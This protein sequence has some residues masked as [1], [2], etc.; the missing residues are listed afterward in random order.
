MPATIS[1]VA[2]EAGVSVSAVSAAINGREK[3]ARIS[4]AT[5]KRIWQ[6]VRKLGYRPRAAAR[7]LRSGRQEA[8][9]Y[10]CA[11]S[12]WKLFDSTSAEYMWGIA[13]ELRRAHIRM[14]VLVIEDLLMEEETSTQRFLASCHFDGIVVERPDEREKDIETAVGLLGLPVVWLNRPREDG[15]NCVWRDDQEAA[16]L[17]VEHLVSL[18]HK[19]I[20]YACLGNV[21]E[22]P[23]TLEQAQR[24]RGYERAMEQA[25]LAAR[26]LGPPGDW[27]SVDWDFFSERPAAI[28]A[29][30]MTVA[31]QAQRALEEKG[32]KV[33]ADLSL[34][35]VNDGIDAVRELVRISAISRDREG[36]GACAARKILTILGG[37]K[38]VTYTVFHGDLV[39]RGSTQ[40][41]SPDP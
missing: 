38:D 37:D 18:G 13:R 23:P 25:G 5:S 3:K 27:E 34:V 12:G 35:S 22:R 11:Q 16:E 24:R 32:L 6:V 36:M 4:A 21:D 28:V 15:L 7:A 39:D 9:G 10:L 14:I 40:R 26:F 1:D 8:V 2:R 33:P 31:W 29:Y 30:N 17:A 20:A 41:V 19:R